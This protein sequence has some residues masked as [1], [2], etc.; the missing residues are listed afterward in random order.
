MAENIVQGLFGLNPYQVQQQQNAGLEAFANQQAQ[1]NAAQRGVQGLT[2]GGGMLGQAAA[3]AMG[4]V[5][6]QV[7]EAKIREQALAGIDW[8]DPAAILKRSEQI[9]DPRLSMQLKVLANSRQKEIY[10]QSL[11]QAKT[12]QEYAKTQK[13]L[14]PEDKRTNE[15]KNVEATAI[16]NG[17]QKDTP[18]YNKFVGDML[19]AIIKN[20][21]L[22]FKTDIPVGG[23]KIQA[24]FI[25]KS[26]QTVKLVG[27][28]NTTPTG[29]RIT[30]GQATS[31]ALTPEAID[32]AATRYRLTGTMPQIGLGS[33][34]MKMKILNRA[35]EQ[36]SLEGKSGEATALGQMATKANQQALGQLEKQATMVGAFEKTATANMNLALSLSDKVDRLGSPIFDKW[37][38]AGKKSITGNEEVAK[39]HA[40]NETFINEYAKIM[41]GSM[42]NTAISDAA[43]KNAHEILSNAYTKEQYRAV[44]QTLA[45]EMQNRI[46]GFN[47]QREELMNR[48]ALNPKNK[49]T[50]TSSEVTPKAV[51]TSSAKKWN[52]TK[53]KW[54]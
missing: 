38:Q 54:E 26:G 4:M 30:I 12:I 53:S 21:N 15:Q 29:A 34:A 51:T 32:D 11:T 18:E 42:G 3:G 33:A 49:P 9:S 5:N 17:L 19:N 1:M 44:V 8:N 40:A 41:S 46:Q 27:Q 7:E 25:D 20:P 2:M 39:F 43:R 50:I 35:S 10:D 24:G 37:I 52:S 45:T 28:P 31:N 47:S 14:L 48:S 22:E 36:A 16:A 6:P 23:N 13:E